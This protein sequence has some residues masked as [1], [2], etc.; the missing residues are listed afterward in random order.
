MSSPDPALLSLLVCPETRGPLRYDADHQE[1]IS[2][3]A[4]V[5]YPIRHGIPIMLRD[6]ARTLTDED[7][8]RYA[9]TG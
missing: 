9:V 1:L 4:K 7:L 3:Q 5:A 8:Q 6:E 2:L